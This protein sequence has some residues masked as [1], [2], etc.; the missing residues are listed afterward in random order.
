[1][2][3]LAEIRAHGFDGDVEPGGLLLERSDTGLAVFA[4]DQQTPVKVAEARGLDGTWQGL[5]GVSARRRPAARL[6][7]FEATMRAPR[8]AR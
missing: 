1:M 3:H 6:L 4:A 7:S 5:S 2:Q 8:A